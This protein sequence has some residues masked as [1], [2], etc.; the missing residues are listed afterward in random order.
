MWNV[1]C[2]KAE[3][4][5]SVSCLPCLWDGIIQLYFMDELIVMPVICVSESNVH[6]I[7]FGSVAKKHV[8]IRHTNLISRKQMSI[9]EIKECMTRFFGVGRVEETGKKMQLRKVMIFRFNIFTSIQLIL[10]T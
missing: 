4:I 3:S 6:V 7:L 10:C 5:D 2:V 9:L 1:F 8:Q